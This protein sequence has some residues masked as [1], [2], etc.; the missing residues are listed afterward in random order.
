MN[1]FSLYR[2][3]TVDG[4]LSEPEGI[5]DPKYALPS[6]I[7]WVKSYAMLLRAQ[8]ITFY[9]GSNFYKTIKVH[10]LSDR[11]QN[12]I[13]E[14]LLLAV[15]QLSA[16]QEMSK[17][18]EIADVSRVASVAWYYGIYAAAT[19]MV[20]AQDGSLQD[21]HTQTAK[22]WCRQFAERGLVMSP[23]NY[24]LSTLVKKAANIELDAYRTGPRTNLVNSP[25][26][27]TD[28]HN[29]LCGYLS[30]TRKWYA[31]KIEEELKSSKEFRDN[32]FQNFKTKAAR[33]LRD[34]RL[35]KQK[36]S[37]LHQAIRFRGKA[38]YRE[39]MY[40]AHGSSVKPLI[41][42]FVSDLSV[43]LESFLVMSGAF[44]F[45]RLGRDLSKSFIK[46]IDKYRA[47]SLDPRQLWPIT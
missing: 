41:G 20:A 44:C 7:N 46:D 28:A 30:G 45:Q 32:K 8:P 42:N 14:H 12:S 1:N 31:W 3:L 10:Q 33:E 19:A 24:Y 35:G 47:F 4:T 6:T 29:Y 23:F 5:P 22:S 39:A 21:N 38:N 18:C 27:I 43:V 17:S 13:F 16:L 34:N 11:E 15:H 37:F 9:D 40:L 26:N 25:K 2:R 36:I